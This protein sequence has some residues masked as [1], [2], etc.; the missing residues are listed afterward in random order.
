MAWCRRWHGARLGRRAWNWGSSKVRWRGG[1]ARGAL[2]E[3]A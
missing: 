1:R 2:Q 3:C